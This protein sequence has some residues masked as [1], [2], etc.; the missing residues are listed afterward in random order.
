MTTLYEDAMAK[1]LQGITSIDEVLAK[2]K[3]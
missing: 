2:I 3:E 1:V